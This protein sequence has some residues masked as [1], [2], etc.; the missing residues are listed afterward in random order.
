MNFCIDFSGGVLY[1]SVSEGKHPVNT[2]GKGSAGE[3]EAEDL[4]V[5]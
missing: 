1:I 2:L 4:K 5:W 3:H